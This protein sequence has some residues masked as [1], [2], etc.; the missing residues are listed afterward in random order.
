MAI[1]GVG[2]VLALV[3]RRSLR[4]PS[5]AAC[6]ADARGQA[7]S[8]APRCSACNADLHVAGALRLRG[9]DRSW[10]WIVAWLV[11]IGLGGG[12]RYADRTINEP[13]GRWDIA[14]IPTWWDIR[15]LASGDVESSDAAAWRLADRVWSD[16]VS[17]EEL[18][19]IVEAVVARIDPRRTPALTAAVDELLVA[20][21]DDPRARG[22]W[23]ERFRPYFDGVQL[24]FNGGVSSLTV[25]RQWAFGFVS[26]VLI[27]EVRSGNA[28]ATFRPER[29]EAP[30]APNRD[31]I[32]ADRFGNRVLGSIEWPHGP[33]TAPI[34]V[35]WRAVYV[36]AKIARA[37]DRDE[38]ALSESDPK[39]WGVTSL[40]V[41]GM[42]TFR[43]DGGPLVANTTAAPP[44]AG[45]PYSSMNAILVDLRPWA[46][47]TLVA[48]CLLAFV[49]IACVRSRPSRWSRLA[50]PAC[51]RC[52]SALAPFERSATAVCSEC[53]RRLRFDLARFAGCPSR[54]PQYLG[55]VTLAIAMVSAMLGVAWGFRGHLL[56]LA[57]RPSDWPVDSNGLAAFRVAL[58]HGDLAP[59]FM[60]QVSWKIEDD[61]SFALELV[62]ILHELDPLVLLRSEELFHACMDLMAIGVSGAPDVSFG[63]TRPIEEFEYLSSGIKGQHVLVFEHSLL[64]R[65]ESLELDGQA[66]TPV[67]GEYSWT[68]PDERDSAEIVIRWFAATA[69]KRTPTMSRRISVR[70]AEEEVPIDPVAMIPL[71]DPK[72]SPFLSPPSVAMLLVGERALVRVTAGGEWS[73]F[74]SRIQGTWTIEADGREF[75]L[76]GSPPISGFF[77]GQPGPHVVEALLGPFVRWPPEEITLRFHPRPFQPGTRHWAV[78]ERT[79]LRRQPSTDM[80]IDLLD[81]GF[82][83]GPLKGPRAIHYAPGPDQ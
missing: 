23:L 63:V 58:A 76:G 25:K 61:R 50:V 26:C 74:D 5:C 57:L 40:V 48:V 69:M 32:E 27:D 73:C 82:G 4:R 12:L 35:R 21:I 7:W 47:P 64:W 60:E 62:A 78:E 11:V 8:D 14:V 3:G 24:S 30:L 53:G 28:V 51:Q 18:E 66:I 72:D 10:R 15:Q 44:S 45:R 17:D 67:N 37:I 68:W 55:L 9:R 83:W 33:P 13:F 2:L 70:L 49:A 6:G 77:S 22:E 59:E 52:S 81:R 34:E 41:E 75:A 42:T 79:V 39:K 19:S 16:R 56:W 46:V 38:I 54:W 71:T 36:P 20:V 80:R 43:S 1:G 31:K 65:I 29:T